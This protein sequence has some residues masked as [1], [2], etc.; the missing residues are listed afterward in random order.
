[1]NER[2]VNDAMG[3][4]KKTVMVTSDPLD[5]IAEKINVSRSK[6]KV[7]VSSDFEGSEADDFNDK[8][9]VKKADEKKRD[10]S[11]VK[12]YN[13]K[14]EGHF[15]KDCKKAKVNC[16]RCLRMCFE[17]LEVTRQV[18][19]RDDKWVPTKKRVKT[20]ITNVRQETNVPQKEET[21]QVI[22]DV[23]ENST[24]YKAF[25]ISAEVP[26]IFMQQF[27]YTVKKVSGVDFSEVLDD[28]ATLT[29]LLSLG[30]KGPLHKHPIMYVDHIHQPWRTL[31][32]IINKCLSGKTA[33]SD[34]LRKSR[35]DILW[36][37][38]Y[39]ENVDY[40]E[41]ICEDFTFQIDYKQMKKGKRKNMP[42][43]RLKFVRIG[44]DCQEY[45][46]S[47][48]EIM[49]IDRIKQ[50]E[51]YQ[52]F[53]KYS[54][55]QIS[56]KKSKG[57]GSQG[58]KTAYTTEVTVDVSKESDSERE[59]GK[60][61]SLTKDAEEEAIRQVHV[62]HAR[63]VTEPVLEPPRRRPSGIDF[64]DTSSVSKKMSS[65]PSQKLKGIQTLTLKEQIV[66][67]TMKALKESNNTSRRQP[68]TR[69]SNEGTSVS[70]RVLDESTVV[71][72]IPSEETGTKLGV[73]DEENVT[74]E[75]NVI[76]EWGSEQNSEYSKEED[77]GET[78][79]WVDTDEEEEEKNDDY[80][81]SIN[82]E[83]ANNEEIDDEFV[84]VNDNEDEEMTNV[85]VEESRN[86]DEEIT[87]VA[88]VDAGKTEEVKDDAKKA[89][90]PLTSSSLSS[91]PVLTVHV[92]VIFKPSVV[93]PIPKTPLVAP[94]TTL[95]PPPYV[96]TIPPVLRQT[97]TPIPSQPISTKAPTITTAILE[98]DALTRHTPD[99]IQ[100]YFVKPALEPSKIQTPIINLE[101]ESEKSDIEIRKIKKEQVEKQKMPKYTIK[102]TDK[103]SLKEYDQKSALYQTM[104]ENKTFNKSP[105]NH[106][107]YH[108][109]MKELIEDENAIDKG[110]IDTVK[111]HNRQ[112][113]DDEDDDEDPSAG[114]SQVM[115]DLKTTANEYMVND[116]N[117]LQD[118]EAP[119]TKKPSRDTWFKK[120]PRT[121]TLD[122]EC[123]LTVAA[124]YFFNNDLELLK[125]SDP[126]KKYTT[127]ITKTKAARYEIM[128]FEDMVS[129]LWSTTKVGVSVKKLHGYGHLEAIAVKKSLSTE[130]TRQVAARD[131]KWVPIKEIV[132]TSTTN[133][134]LE[135]NVSQ[136]EETFQVIID[137][138]ENSTGYKAFTISAEVLKIFMQQ[139]WY[140]VKK[141][142]DFAEVLD[143]EAT[144]TFLLSLGYKGPLH[145]HPIMYM[146]HMHQPWRTLALI[147]NKCL[148]DFT[149][150]I[151]Y[152]QLKKGKRKNILYPRIKQS[153]SYQ[154]FI[155]YSTGQISPKKSRGK[156]SQGKKTAYTTEATVDV[157]KELNSE[158]LGKS[159]SLTKSA[160]EEAT[161]QVHVTH[162]RIVIEPIPKPA[163]KR[164]S[165]QIVAD[166]MKALKESNKT[167][168]RQPC[169]RSL[170]EGTSCSPGVLDESTV[171]LAIPSEETGTKP[172]VLDE[173]N[174]T[175]EANVILEWG[176]EQNSEY[177]KEE[178]DGEIIEWVDTDKEDE[179]KNDDYDKSINLEQTDNEENDDEFVYVNDNED[180]Q[181]TNAELEESQKDDEEITN[182][183]KVDAGKTEEV[184]DSLS[185]SSGFADQFLKLSSD[186]SLIG[187]I[188]DTI[189]AEINSL[190]DIKIQS[191][192]PH[193]HGSY[194]N[195]STTSLL[196]PPYVSTIPSVLRQTTTPIPSQPIST[197]APTIT[198]AIPK[199][200][201]LTAV[202]LRVAKFKNDVFELKK[203]DHSVE[204]L[205]SIKSQVPTP[206][207]EPSKIQTPIID[208]EPESKK[209]T[210]EIRKIKK[211]Q[212]EK[213]M[214]SKYTI[215]YTD[216][217]SLKEYDQKS[218]LYQ[219]LN[220]NKTF[221]RSPA[222][223]E[224]YHVLMEAF[225]EDENAIDKGVVDTV[226][227]HNRQHD[228]DEDD[229]EEP[230]ARPSQGNKRKRE[231]LK[232][233]SLP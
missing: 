18:A 75:A 71:L 153:E 54:T 200:D 88:K 48:P 63:I 166:T 38:L 74:F 195:S 183:A 90:L 51:S 2:D 209:S 187:T 3:S 214:M 105:T 7:V 89:E 155:K 110:V 117:R 208:L 29:F 154:M 157:S 56:P 207:L 231:E 101:P 151:D 176:S 13:C 197:K 67:D 162:V 137:V 199:S 202:H 96:S 92:L 45:G 44:E 32:S 9:V 227:N 78:I 228:D 194:N 127:S 160:E 8:Q 140:T 79:K 42:Y 191:E 82:L 57:K 148:S 158:H 129:T 168:R 185:V 15:A 125:S 97:T 193:I 121:L 233:Q 85:E 135:N 52:M 139:F 37:M 76:L 211:E 40:P 69:S 226:K 217:A 141:V 132:K 17:P 22:I 24:Y 198:T 14:K 146:D 192:V 149:F 4:K 170:N 61:I 188:K 50:S 21:F 182:A 126:E 36:G 66:A 213:Q 196:P 181:M 134:R 163:R 93:I 156:G 216:K 172:G 167:S 25:T 81:K 152:R 120:P 70:P 223:H 161:R 6:E 1:Q 165:E 190:L 206:A 225:I 131:K 115:D 212:V 219:T 186:T 33:S 143:D 136:K 118:S 11:R 150:Q 30:Y 147:I 133:V 26:K 177:S 104:N 60:S 83:Q 138:I 72:A 62:T 49:L 98:S 169:T 180:E 221:N 46:L 58:N 142:S 47:I 111:N 41:L 64:R 222:N 103:A 124:E 55:G 229:D 122:P 210:L 5:L 224:L 178:D 171:V 73:L 184:K 144:L 175:F 173:E 84:H 174:V 100:K 16:L 31:A 203:I 113:D 116:A 205:A 189:D 77:D 112:H 91:P 59:L 12:C 87:D 179:K 10:V 215:K 107:L 108:V 94:T 86:D 230:S 106:E 102:Y 119:K 80:D 95:L 35:I 164:P 68:C 145:K 99:L 123:R 201:V 114:P 34:R 65:D 53:I 23:I 19:A 159:I 128:G 232:S 130:V 39:R 27:W 43:P 20:S 220:E 109:L 218:A 204:A 28:E